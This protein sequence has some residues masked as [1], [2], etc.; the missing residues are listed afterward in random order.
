MKKIIFVLFMVLAL[1]A[2]SLEARVVYIRTALTGGG[3]SA[4]DGIDGASLADGDATI[5]FYNSQTYFYYLNATS[6]ATASSP[7]VISP[8]ANAGTK[9]WLL[10]GMVA[11][12][13]S[14]N[15][16]DG[17]CY[18]LLPNN[19]N[20]APTASSNEIYPEGTTSAS[21]WK[22]N[23]YGNE[24]IIIGD[25]TVDILSGKTL[26][27][28]GSGLTPGSAYYQG[29]SALALAKADSATTMPAVCVAVSSTQCVYSGEVTTG[30]WT[31]GDTIYIDKTTAGLLTATPPTSAGN[32]VQRFG[33]AT[34]TTT[35]LVIPSLDVGTVATP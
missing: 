30:S 15:C 28:S 29:A 3:A 23:N 4:L 21:R 32:Q 5:V 17:N 31:K 14:G 20:R 10:Q 8:T 34:S 26:A 22:M 18:L 24:S 19:T 13:L 6:G 27:L 33:K 1:T 7:L 16:A 2:G 9:R 35:I 11:T 12:S 25:I